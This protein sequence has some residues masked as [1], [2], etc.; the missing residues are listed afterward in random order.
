MRLSITWLLPPLEP[1]L[2]FSWQKFI[3]L[4]KYLA[5]GLRN[6]H[7]D[8]NSS[9]EA[10]FYR[11]NEMVGTSD[12]LGQETRKTGGAGGRKTFRGPAPGEAYVSRTEVSRWPFTL[13]SPGVK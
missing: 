4:H 3:Y 5:L 11:D 12:F 1:P 7:I 13:Y 9:E 8:V 10:D 2:C 6:D